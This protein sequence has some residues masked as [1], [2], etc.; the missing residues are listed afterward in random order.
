MREPKVM[1]TKEMQEAM[2]K[3]RKAL[4]LAIRS[5]PNEEVLDLVSAA[6]LMRND[7]DEVAVKRFMKEL[8]NWAW[9]YT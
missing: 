2:N 9:E 3:H 4:T 7:Y 1:L 8:S 5:L 6:L